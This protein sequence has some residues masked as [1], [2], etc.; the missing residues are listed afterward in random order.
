MREYGTVRATGNGE[1]TARELHFVVGGH[2]FGLVRNREGRRCRSTH[3]TGVKHSGCPGFEYV[4][5]A[6]H[7]GAEQ[8]ATDIAVHV[9]TQLV[10]VI[11]GGGNA[12]CQPPQQ[13]AAFVQIAVLKAQQAG[14]FTATQ[15]VFIQRIRYARAQNSQLA[16]ARVAKV[17]ADQRHGG[18]PRAQH[19]LL[20]ACN[21]EAH[22]AVVGLDGCSLHV[23]VEF[24]DQL[25]ASVQQIIGRLAAAVGSCD[26]L[27][28]RSNAA[29]Q[30]VDV[31]DFLR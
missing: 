27:V 11:H 22:R 10:L 15:H 7:D 24:L 21:I 23:L 14:D 6:Q 26:L 20:A 9:Q 30:A 31:G 16:A 4:V 25:I 12:H 1:A 18:S 3:G 17:V 5:G 13:I 29:C 28:Q 8:V 19:Q 2:E